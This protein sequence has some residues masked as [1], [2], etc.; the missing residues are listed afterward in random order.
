[1]VLSMI[2]FCLC[3]LGRKDRLLVGIWYLV[4]SSCFVKLTF[5]VMRD[6]VRGKAEGKAHSH[7]TH[8]QPQV[9]RLSLSSLIKCSTFLIL[10][11]HWFICKVT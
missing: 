6:I 4:L 8:L 5:F 9:C 1:M 2:A 3:S 7:F 11:L 10:S